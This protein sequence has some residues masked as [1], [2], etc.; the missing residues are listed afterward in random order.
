MTLWG[1]LDGSC[2]ICKMVSVGDVRWWHL[3]MS[4]GGCGEMLGSF[5]EWKVVSVG[6]LDGRCTGC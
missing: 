5:G 6:M 1:M 3:G 2:E 4:D